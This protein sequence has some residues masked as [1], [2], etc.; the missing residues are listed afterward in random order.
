MIDGRTHVRSVITTL[1][2]AEHT[3]TPLTLSDLFEGELSEYA[4]MIAG[5]AMNPIG[6]MTHGEGPAFTEHVRIALQA[7][8]LSA[9][10]IERQQAMATWFEHKRGFFKAEWLRTAQGVEPLA[11]IYFRRR[12][13]IE[14]VIARFAQW[15]LP[16][17]ARERVSAMAAVLEKTSI[18][19]VSAAFRPSHPVHHKVYFSQWV[20]KDTRAAVAARIARVFE[21]FGF[22][23]GAHEAWLANHEHCIGPDDT[24]VFVSTSVSA[25][26]VS[27]TFKID[28]PDLT[29]E[30]VAAWLPVAQRATVLD[31]ARRAMALG[32]T[33]H[34]TFT[35]VRF[36]TDQPAPT[37]KYYS[38]VPGS[39]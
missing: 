31:E 30:L 27:P 36:A 25:D 26:G 29:P 14:E 32:G 8:G 10:A 9:A 13:G 24:T 38:D 5:R 11:A 23:A 28:Y 34:L 2:P 15:G 4:E 33:K 37:L 39:R 20:T 19:F 17:A 12:P 3:T 22:Q 6:F 35:G 7:L 21:L 18:H 1:L 16:D